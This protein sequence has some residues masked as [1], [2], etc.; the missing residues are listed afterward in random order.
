M[1]DRFRAAMAARDATR[2]AR[3]ARLNALT[4]DTDAAVTRLRAATD[5][6]Q[7]IVDDATSGPSGPF[8]HEPPCDLTGCASRRPDLHTYDSRCTGAYDCPVTRHVHGC[9]ADLDGSRCDDPG[10]H[11]PVNITSGRILMGTFPASAL[12]VKAGALDPGTIV[13]GK[14][15]AHGGYLPVGHHRA[16]ALASVP[17]HEQVRARIAERQR[18]MEAQ[19]DAIDDFVVLGCPTHERFRG[20]NAPAET[21]CADAT[22]A[23]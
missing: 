23:T 1:F 15:M 19:L 16:Q 3:K 10:D 7:T 18:E 12:A 22:P 9:F 4:A 17:G 20:L 6:M 8:R 21:C 14:I 2:R 5:R 11:G 13:S